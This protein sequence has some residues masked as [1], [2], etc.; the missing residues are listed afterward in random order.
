MALQQHNMQ[1]LISVAYLTC[2]NKVTSFGDIGQ[3]FTVWATSPLA[4]QFGHV[5]A[6]KIGHVTRP[7][8][9][10]K[11]FTQVIINKNAFQ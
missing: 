2:V 9:S 1:K 7:V 4:P 10:C 5:Y 8:E 6:R 11:I 3:Y